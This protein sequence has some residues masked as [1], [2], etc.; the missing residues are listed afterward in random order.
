MIAAG[1]GRLTVPFPAEG[2]PIDVRVARHLS[3]VRELIATM[4]T[5]VPDRS[6]EVDGLPSYSEVL[7]GG[8]G[9]YLGPP[10]GPG[11]TTP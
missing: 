5:L 4:S 9:R 1:R 3:T 7:D 10:H 8:V 2:W 6:V 11:R